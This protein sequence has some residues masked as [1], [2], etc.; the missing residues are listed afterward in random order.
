MFLKR[1]FHKVPWRVPENRWELYL[2]HLQGDFLTGTNRYD[3]YRMSL[4]F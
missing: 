2:F 3:Q 4:I 1:L